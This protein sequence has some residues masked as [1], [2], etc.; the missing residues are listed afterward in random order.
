MLHKT[1]FWEDC[2][3]NDA[4][5]RLYKPRQQKENQRCMN[6]KEEKNIY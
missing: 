6:R 4:K 1:Q 3:F 5:E 2:A